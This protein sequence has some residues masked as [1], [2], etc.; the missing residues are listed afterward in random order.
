MTLE[1]DQSEIFDGSSRNTPIETWFQ[2]IEIIRMGS[3]K[4]NLRTNQLFCSPE[5]RDLLGFPI[6]PGKSTKING[7]LLYS[8]NSATVPCT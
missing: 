1:V 8:R 6:N 3:W 7:A 2:L 4:L 5:T